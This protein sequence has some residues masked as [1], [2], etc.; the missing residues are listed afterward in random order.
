MANL[1]VE[2]ADPGWVVPFELAP[3]RPFRI[4]GI[5][6]LVVDCDP[7]GGNPVYETRLRYADA[8]RGADSPAAPD[9]D[10]GSVDRVEGQ[11]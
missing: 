8:V 4:F 3:T 10:P 11:P 5:V 1:V 7:N 2:R 6:T 9:G